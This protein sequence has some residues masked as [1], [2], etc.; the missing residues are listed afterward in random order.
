M[1]EQEGV[2]PK[3]FPQSREHEIVQN[4]LRGAM[5][6][7]SAFTPSP[8]SMADQSVAPP[9]PSPAP[10]LPAESPKPIAVPKSAL[11]GDR[12]V[13]AAAAITP[14][15]RKETSVH[16]SNPGEAISTLPENP[17]PVTS[18]SESASPPDRGKE[19]F[20]TMPEPLTQ[21]DVSPEPPG[22]RADPEAPPFP[23]QNSATQLNLTSNYTSS[24]HTPPQSPPAIIPFFPRSVIRPEI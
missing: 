1:L 20:P 3:L 16:L 23:A 14:P 7:V 2:I 19:S 18:A 12:A 17:P 6:E 22:R 13:M 15:P 8:P 5:A 4:V 10:S 9:S 11:Y 24:S 21:P